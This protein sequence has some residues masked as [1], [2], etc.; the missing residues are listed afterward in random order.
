VIAMTTYRS[1]DADNDRPRPQVDPLRP[2]RLACPCGATAERDGL[3][4]KCRA[5][6]LWGRRNDG[7]RARA[8]R[9]T[10]TRPHTRRPE[11]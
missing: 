9:P 5:R 11:R 1:D 10:P 6:A 3:C 8:S 7:R 4:R 2:A